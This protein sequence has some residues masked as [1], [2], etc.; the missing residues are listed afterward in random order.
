M[1]VRGRPRINGDGKEKSRMKNGI[2]QRSDG[3]YT[4]CVPLPRDPV[5]GKPRQKWETVQGTKKDAERRKAELI[6]EIA[7]GFGC[8]ASNNLITEEYLA[9][10]LQSRATGR[11]GTYRTLKTSFNAYKKYIAKIPLNKLI[12]Y[13]INK[14]KSN[15]LKAGIA[16]RTVRKYTINLKTALK[17]AVD[18]GL[19]TRSPGDGVK[20]PGFRNREIQVWTQDQVRTIKILQQKARRRYHDVIV[21]ALATGARL[22]EILAL[23]WSDINLEKEIVYI[24]RTVS[25]KGYNEPKTASGSR[26]ILIDKDTIVVLKE[27]RK[28]QLQEKLRSGNP[29]YNLENLVFVTKNG[30]RPYHDAIERSLTSTCK[31]AGLPKIRVHDLSYPH[32]NKIRTFSKELPNQRKSQEKGSDNKSLFH[33]AN[34][35]E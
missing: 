25:G 26:Q 3:S 13:D 32:L 28:E 16:P 21:F 19:I 11:E 17:N 7:K 5:T 1:K 12:P 6:T 14:A 10:Y 35:A 31:A 27:H 23:R 9:D 29:D 33:R 24:K 2:V 22:G 20:L 34:A 4:V 15:M 8:L 30:R 18:E